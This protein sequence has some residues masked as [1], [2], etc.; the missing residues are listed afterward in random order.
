MATSNPLYN[1]LGER[2]PLP[3]LTHDQEIALAGGTH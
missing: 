1:Y 2:A 3:L